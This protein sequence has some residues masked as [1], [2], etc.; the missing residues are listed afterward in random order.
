MSDLAFRCHFCYRV[1][2]VARREVGFIRTCACGKSLRVPEVE[3]MPPGTPAEQLPLGERVDTPGL[4]EVSQAVEGDAPPSAAIPPII[5]PPPTDEEIEAERQEEEKRAAAKAAQ[6]EAQ[7][8]AERAAALAAAERVAAREREALDVPALTGPAEPIV[9][10]SSADVRGGAESPTD[11]A[12][13]LSRTS[14]EDRASGVEVVPEDAGWQA[15]EAERLEPVPVDIQ[16]LVG[17]EEPPASP[18]A[19]PAAVRNPDSGSATMGKGYV[20]LGIVCFIGWIVHT[21]PWI[22]FAGGDPLPVSVLGADHTHYFGLERAFWS[23]A[24]FGLAFALILEGWCRG[25]SAPRDDGQLPV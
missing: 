25:R 5:P 4:F 18:T 17:N 2:H 9:S 23:A 11:S 21:S 22:Y 24:I 1:H 6:E 12:V 8:E 16:P 3:A 10:Q 19:P 20:T 7:R 14:G 15:T 13:A